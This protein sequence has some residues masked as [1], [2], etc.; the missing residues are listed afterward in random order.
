MPHPQSLPSLSP[1]SPHP[2]NNNNQTPPT[3]LLHVDLKGPAGLALGAGARPHLL[4]LPLVEGPQEEAA[5]EAVILDHAELGED[6]RAAGDHPVGAYQ[7]VEVQLPAETIA[8]QP[9]SAT[10]QAITASNTEKN[11]RKSW[12]FV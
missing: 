5:L 12:R 10:M 11:Q 2:N 9:N 6:A 3:H 7:Q 8:T 1:A 4:V